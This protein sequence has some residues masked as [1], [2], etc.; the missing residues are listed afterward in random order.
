[1]IQEMFD[2]DAT[3][4]NDVRENLAIITCL[5]KVLDEAEKKKRRAVE[6]QD[7]EEKNRS[8]D[9]GWRVIL[10]CTTTTSLILQ[11]MPTIFGSAIG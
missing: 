11:H 9:R 6:V 4:N 10:F 2:D 5:Q 8:P 3:C 7:R 1:M